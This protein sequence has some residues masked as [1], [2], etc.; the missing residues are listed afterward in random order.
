MRHDTEPSNEC[1]AQSTEDQ[2]EKAPERKD[3]HIHR[4][5]LTST[6]F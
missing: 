6:D 5:Y 1:T 4:S 3:I 2:S